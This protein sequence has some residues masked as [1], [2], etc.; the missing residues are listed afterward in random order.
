[1]S[2]RGVAPRY[3]QW[4]SAPRPGSPAR[5]YEVG[6][7]KADSSFPSECRDVKFL[8]QSS[9]LTSKV[10]TAALRIA[11]VPSNALALPFA[12]MSVLKNCRGN[13]CL[14]HCPPSRWSRES[15][16]TACARTPEPATATHIIHGDTVNGSHARRSTRVVSR[17]RYFLRPFWWQKDF[18]PLVM[19][20]GA[21]ARRP[22]I[23]ASARFK[24]G[25]KSAGVP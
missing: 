9:G 15:T 14:F 3:K 6:G 5:I 7:G 10:I 25:T 23:L 1:L 2:G 17:F 19:G 4:L 13:C 24:P 12:Q 18:H 11:D 20:P 21:C 8:P 16:S 22:T